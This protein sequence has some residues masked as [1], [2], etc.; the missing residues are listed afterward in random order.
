MNAAST[1]KCVSG[2][3]VVGE[4]CLVGNHVKLV[5]SVL[6]DRVTVEDGCT[7]QNCILCSGCHLQVAQNLQPSPILPLQYYIIHMAQEIS[8]AKTASQSV[9]REG[10]R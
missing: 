7:V 5:N 2:C 8:G 4:N 3:S 9:E 1:L 6:M 10:I